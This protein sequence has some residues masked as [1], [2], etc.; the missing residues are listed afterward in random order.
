MESNV[1]VLFITGSNEARSPEILIR[2]LQV[3]GR[4][5]ESI[6]NDNLVENYHHRD[7][8]SLIKILFELTLRKKKRLHAKRKQQGKFL[9]VLQIMIIFVLI[10]ILCY[11]FPSTIGRA[12]IVTDEMLGGNI[13]N[14]FQIESNC[15][16]NKL[17]L[18]SLKEK[19]SKL[20]RDFNNLQIENKSLGKKIKEQGDT[21]EKVSKRNEELTLQTEKDQSTILNLTGDIRNLERDIDELEKMIKEIN[22]DWNRVVEPFCNP[23]LEIHPQVKAYLKDKVTQRNCPNHR[24]MK[25]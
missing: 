7:D 8:N 24:H 9:N 2:S 5:W 13:M 18:A 20:E 16:F 22:D 14:A 23:A 3:G 10:G 15:T 4:E 6:L 25:L 11:S 12:I 21:L 17:Q 1:S 19:H